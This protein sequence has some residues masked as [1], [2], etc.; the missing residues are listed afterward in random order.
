MKKLI[1]FPIIVLL[2]SCKADK[3][4]TVES[5]GKAGYGMTDYSEIIRH[6]VSLTSVLDSN[7]ISSIE[8]I[9]DTL[10]FDTIQAGAVI[11]RSFEFRN[12]GAKPLYIL[13]TKVSC[14]CTVT[15]YSNKA[16]APGDTGSIKV[17]FD[18]EGKSGYQNKSILVLSNSYPNED[19]L[20]LQGYV[21]NEIK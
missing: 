11:Q 13:D 2:L 15:D 1:C 18:S 7:E 4:R 9:E 20:Y 5:A 3:G 6:P 12:I 14:G 17:K 8:F 19:R 21:K 16:I 10:S